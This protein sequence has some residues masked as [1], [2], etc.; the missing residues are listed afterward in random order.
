[1]SSEK[2]K[3]VSLNKKHI[4]KKHIDKCVTFWNA[5]YALFV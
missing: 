3:L 1:M 4:Q 5:D 2:G